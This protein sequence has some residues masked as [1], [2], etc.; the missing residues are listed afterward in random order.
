MILSSNSPSL[1]HSDRL[2]PRMQS[3]VLGAT[4][5]LAEAAADYVKVVATAGLDLSGPRAGRLRAVATAA[6]S[7]VDFGVQ[8]DNRRRRRGSPRSSSSWGQSG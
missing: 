5:E 1:G 8:P 6:S 2:A 3:D 7:V 4:A